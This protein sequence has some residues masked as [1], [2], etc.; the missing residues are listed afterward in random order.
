MRFF[1]PIWVLLFSIAAHGATIT[2]SLLLITGAN[3]PDKRVTF[4]PMDAPFATGINTTL[5][6]STTVTSV[7]GVFTATIAQGSYRVLID[8]QPV[9]F[10]RV[11]I[12]SATYNINSLF[13]CFVYLASECLQ[14]PATNSAGLLINDGSGGLSWTNVVPGS[15]G[16]APAGTVINSTIASGLPAVSAYTNLV[17]ATP[18][19][20][21]SALGFSPQPTNSTLTR[22]AGIG[23]GAA[24]DIVYRD[25]TGW[26][27]R[28][29]GSNGQIL[30]LSGGLPVWAADDTG[31]WTGS[32]S[33]NTTLTGVAS[34]YNLLASQYVIAPMIHATTDM[35][36]PSLTLNGTTRTTW[37]SGGGGIWGDITGTLADQTDLQAAINAKLNYN[38]NLDAMGG[39]INGFVTKLATGV[40]AA[41]T[42]TAGSSQITV[43]YGDGVTGNPIIDLGPILSGNI[44]SGLG[45]TP[46]PTDSDLTA[47]AGLSTTGLISRTGTGTMATRTI[48]AG[49]GKVTVSNGNGVSGSP[50]IDIGTGIDAAS[51]GTGLISNTEFSYLDNLPGN[52]FDLLNTK[53]NLSGGIIAGDLT[54]TGNLY[55]S[56][57]FGDFGTSLQL[58]NYLRLLNATASRVLVTD[59]NQYVTNSSV[60]SATLAFVDLTSSAQTQLDSKFPIPTQ[61]ALTHAGTVTLS[62]SA[63]STES[64]LVLTGAVTFA[65]S[66]LAAAHRYTIFGRNTQATNCTPTFPA[67][68]W[69]SGAP[70]TITSGKEWVLSLNS[71]GTVAT[72]VYAAYAEAP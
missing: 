23:A 29:K 71:R 53:L 46:Q 26:T 44:T 27:N 4:T 36:T 32:S 51:I 22:L 11:P 31:N 41:R 8:G 45:Y 59:A 69:P 48:T 15:G 12:G 21:I 54:V 25:V 10:I 40:A 43:Q 14:F 70:P 66:G 55:L 60:S 3:S 13:A 5:W 37:P 7:D 49:S 68:R 9:G 38:I 67:W 62:L 1:A 24:G 18:A 35:S 19:N 63:L 47:V 50:T 6:P 28:V 58:T 64:D 34:V 57:G 72:N 2:G 30:K 52:I 33:T 16:S 17:A 61:T 42:I 39:V 56:G 20:V 65:T